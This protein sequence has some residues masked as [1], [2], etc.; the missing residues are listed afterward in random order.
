MTRKTA[1]SLRREAIDISRNLERYVGITECL[2]AL[3]ESVGCK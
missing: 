2:M 1:S 3:A